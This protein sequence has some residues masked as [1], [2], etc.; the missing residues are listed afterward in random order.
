MYLFNVSA[1]SQCVYMLSVCVMH[2]GAYR[3]HKLCAGL[4]CLESLM[5]KC[6]VVVYYLGCEDIGVVVHS[7][8]A[9]NENPLSQSSDFCVESDNKPH[10]CTQISAC[11]CSC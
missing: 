4:M 2:K 6:V 9:I 10:I 3:V 7:L 5:R 8:L 1:C 11:V